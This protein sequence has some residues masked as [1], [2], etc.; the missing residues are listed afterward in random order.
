MNRNIFYT[1]AIALFLNELACF[2]N[3]NIMR[4]LFLFFAFI[5]FTSNSISQVGVGTIT[6][7]ASSVLDISATDKGI[8]IPQVSLLDIS[9]TMLDGVNTA[10]TGL[11]IFNTNAGTTGGSG[12]GYY[13]FNGTTWERLTTSASTTTDDDWYEENTTT[14]SNDIND[15]IYTLGNVA[16]GKNTA[17]WPLDVEEDQGEEVFLF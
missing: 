17:D 10:A 12:V 13:Y 2:I 11:L 8:L 5:C 6:P 7:D 14:S 16:I 3:F 9:D 15:D 4:R 1:F